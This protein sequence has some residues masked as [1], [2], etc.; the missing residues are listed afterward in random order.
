MGW[1]TGELSKS[2]G[3]EQP[4]EGSK[5]LVGDDVIDEEGERSA[6]EV[7]T[8]S[9]VVEVPVQKAELRCTGRTRKPPK[10]LVFHAYLPPAAFT[11]M[12]DDAEDDVDL[13]ELDHDV[14]ADPEHS[15]D[16]ATMM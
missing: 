6:G 5:Q 8:D 9:N 12:Y 3:A 2:A 14:H 7:S 1:S 11:T 13:P 4:I 10:R 16:I 15:L